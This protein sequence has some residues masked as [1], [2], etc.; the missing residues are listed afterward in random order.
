MQGP[1]AKLLDKG[2]ADV[3]GCEA[4]SGSGAYGSGILKDVMAVQGGVD[5]RR[6]KYRCFVFT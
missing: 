4:F 1:R 5:L 6:E 3:Y 2:M